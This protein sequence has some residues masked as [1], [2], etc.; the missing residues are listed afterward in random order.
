ML[1]LAACYRLVVGGG[2]NPNDGGGGPPNGNGRSGRP[3]PPQSP[4]GYTGR[5]GG[6][7]VSYA[8]DLPRWQPPEERPHKAQMARRANGHTRQ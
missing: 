4:P 5:P 3:R 1:T 8:A 6:T 2:N 7:Q